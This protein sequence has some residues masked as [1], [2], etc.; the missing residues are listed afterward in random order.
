M[1]CCNS[2]RSTEIF[3]LKYLINF[4]GNGTVFLVSK[5][6]DNIAAYRMCVCALICENVATGGV[7]VWRFYCV[8]LIIIRWPRRRRSSSVH[9]QQTCRVTRPPQTD[10]IN[11]VLRRW[12]VHTYTHRISLLFGADVY[13]ERYLMREYCYWMYSVHSFETYWVRRVW[14][15]LNICDGFLLISIC[16]KT[17]DFL[18]IL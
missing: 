11:R 14:F 13:K 1:T 2:P 18:V 10:V 3:S 4:H 15:N 5:Y 16:F 6:L 7:L 12:L 9:K 17:C 8:A